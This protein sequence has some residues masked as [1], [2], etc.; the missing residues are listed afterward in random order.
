MAAGKDI[1]IMVSGMSGKQFAEYVVR[2]M[3]EVLS[4][5]P[6]SIGIVEARPDQSKHLE[7]AVLE[8][9]GTSVDFVA[10][11][12]EQ[13]DTSS[14]IPT[15]KPGTEQQDAFRRDLTLNSLFYNLETEEI[16]DFTGKGID[17]LRSGIIRTPNK[18]EE[19]IDAK[20]IF[21]QDPLRILR[22]LRFATRFGFTLDPELLKAAKD[23][24]VQAALYKKISRERVQDELR[25]ML[26]GPDPVKAARL[27]KEIGLWDYIFTKPEHYK[28]WDMNQQSSHH[29]FNVWEHTLQ[30]LTNLQQIIK[31]RN[32]NDA[33]KFVLNMAALTHDLGKLDPAIKSEIEVDGNI[34]FQFKGHEEESMKSAEYMLR[35]LPGVKVDEIEKIKKLID[36]A[37]R[38]NPQKCDT[39]EECKMSRKTLGKFIREMGDLWEHAIDLGYADTAGHKI[40]QFKTH[41]VKYYESMKQQI[42]EFE[43][44][45]I[46]TMKP[47]LDGNE[48]MALFGRKGGSWVKELM[49]ALI[50]AQLED[51]N[52]TK[53][54]A[55]ELV[56]RVYVDRGLDKRGYISK[57]AK[58]RLKE[59]KSKRD[60]NKT[61]EPEGKVVS[62]PN[63]H[64]YVI[65]K[66]QA[67]HLHYDLRLENDQGTLTSFAIP[68]HKLP[69][70]K[71]RLLAKQTEDHGIDYVKFEGTIPKGEYGGGTVK[72][73]SEGNKYKPIEWTK[74]TIKFEIPEGAFT[75][76]RMS[77][78]NWLIMRSKEE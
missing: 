11:R 41:P 13:Y 63:K 46:Q 44:A 60:T 72:I 67:T 62:G 61:P 27:I 57:N 6:K 48:L 71:E 58:D 53:E 78:K 42:R 54:Q 36:G 26:T 52:I 77:G 59:Y 20:Y 66:H 70:A 31:S 38:T 3:R 45:K 14:R 34:W 33:D 24:E 56:K 30:V 28:D 1:D 12:V 22:S 68:K 50:D 18:P 4:E 55:I 49:N 7:T 37:R 39:S 43:P 19:G 74:N 64:R 32:L 65:Q 25:K 16:E 23:P 76:R 29:D 73:V 2:Y 40:D 10:P 75:L 15:I 17:D 47:L 8:L 51:S 69:G 21:L 9:Y 35:N 5:M